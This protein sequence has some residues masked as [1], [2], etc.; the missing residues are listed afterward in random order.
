MQGSDLAFSVSKIEYLV[1]S[2]WIFAYTCTNVVN[3]VTKCGVLQ[4]IL[5]YTH[6]HQSKYI[7]DLHLAHTRTVLDV[8]VQNVR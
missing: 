2:L 8:L 6:N 1:L 5:T 3:L 7:N 4:P